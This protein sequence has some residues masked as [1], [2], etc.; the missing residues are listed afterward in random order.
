MLANF[1]NT[2][3][4]SSSKVSNEYETYIDKLKESME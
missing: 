4:E 2:E 1:K 3:N